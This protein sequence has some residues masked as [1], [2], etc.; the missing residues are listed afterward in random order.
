MSGKQRVMLIILFFLIVVTMVCSCFNHFAVYIFLAITV[1]CVFFVCKGAKKYEKKQWAEHIENYKR[2]HINELIKL[3]KR[4]QYNLYSQEGI[5]WL[6]SCCNNKLSQV[7]ESKI[8][9]SLK[10]FLITAVYPVITLMLG[11]LLNK[12]PV[13]QIKHYVAITILVLICFYGMF[14]AI[15]PFLSFLFFSEKMPLQ[16]L[17]EDLEYIKSQ[18]DKDQAGN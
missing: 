18:I 15:S 8:F 9:K 3:L 4:S 12:I 2:K 1:G 6:L 7:E 16:Y 5:E 11:V 13:E 14:L 17:Q 10:A